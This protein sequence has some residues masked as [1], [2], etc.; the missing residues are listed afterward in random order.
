MEKV[1]KFAN[2]ELTTIETEDLHKCISLAISGSI[3]LLK[4]PT[5]ADLK[6]INGLKTLKLLLLQN[7]NAV[8]FKKED[9]WLGKNFTS[10]HGKQFHVPEFMN[11]KETMHIIKCWFYYHCDGNKTFKER[12]YDVIEINTP[13]LDECIIWKQYLTSHKELLKDIFP[14]IDYG[15]DD[16]IFLLP[17]DTLNDY[18]YVNGVGESL[19]AYAKNGFPEVIEKIK[20]IK[21]VE[22]GLEE[23]IYKLKILSEINKFLESM[24]YPHKGSV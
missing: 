24:R 21:K 9:D 1:V 19:Y 2:G 14:S 17:E 16:T 10:I 13:T 20:M 7:N 11:L 15:E 12:R 6:E 8:V 18:V 4:S 5:I 23:S 3:V 22:V